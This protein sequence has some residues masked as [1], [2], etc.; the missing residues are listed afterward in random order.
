MKYFVPVLRLAEELDIQDGLANKIGG[1]PWGLAPER[2]PVCRGCGDPMVHLAQFVHDGRRLDLGREGR[3]LLVF[4]CGAECDTWDMNSGCNA[5]VVLEPEELGEG[6]TPPPGVDLADWNQ[7]VAIHWEDYHVIL[8]DLR[9]ADWIE[10]DDGIAP[11]QEPDFFDDGQY[12]KLM[13]RL[14]ENAEQVFCGAKL[15]GAPGWIQGPEPGLD[16]TWRLAVQL[17]DSYTDLAREPASPDGTEPAVPEKDVLRQWVASTVQEIANP[18]DPQHHQAF[19]AEGSEREAFIDQVVN[20]LEDDAVREMLLPE[21]E[22]RPGEVDGPN[23]GDEGIGYV[24]ITRNPG[25]KRPEAK[26]FWQCH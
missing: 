26:F 4:Q 3:S 7:D 19:G 14:G 12:G 20:A 10:R 21:G 25:D 8:P 6:L 17:Q 16:A 13:D 24:F 1:V 22:F 23:F 2:W 11:E 18:D 9:V 15:G 5:C